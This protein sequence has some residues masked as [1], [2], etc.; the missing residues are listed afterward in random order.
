[1]VLI[2]DFVESETLGT[3]NVLIHV[4]KFNAWLIKLKVRQKAYDV[5]NLSKFLALRGLE[6]EKPM[7]SI[8]NLVVAVE[9]FMRS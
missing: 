7:I 4:E 2:G 8:K 3:S 1:M 5:P 6:S 9:E